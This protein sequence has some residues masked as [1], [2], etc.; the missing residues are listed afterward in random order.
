MWYDNISENRK[1]FSLAERLT[2]LPLVNDRALSIFCGVPACDLEG[3]DFP[4]T[5]S[6]FID[7]RFDYVICRKDQVLLAVDLISAD[8]QTEPSSNSGMPGLVMVQLPVHRMEPMTEKRLASTVEKF[9]R[10]ILSRETS[11]VWRFSCRPVEQKHW[12]ALA[13]EQ[14]IQWTGTHSPCSRWAPT[15]YGEGQGLIAGFYRQE[16]RLFLRADGGIRRKPVRTGKSGGYGALRRRCP[17]P[18]ADSG[19]LLPDSSR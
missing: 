3:G 9:L 1:L 14:M 19:I 5:G 18:P 16:A 6:G 2:E 8:G 13:K 4:E 7:L 12:N 17:A 10:Q 11:G 15:Q